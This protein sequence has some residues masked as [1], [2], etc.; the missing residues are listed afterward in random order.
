[1]APGQLTFQIVGTKVADDPRVTLE[2]V[3]Q[4]GARYSLTLDLT[5]S[6]VA[7]ALTPPDPGALTPPDPG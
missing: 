2:A 4:Y 1:M 7:C 6:L 3:D 5:G